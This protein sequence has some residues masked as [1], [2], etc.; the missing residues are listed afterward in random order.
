MNIRY[1]FKT[2]LRKNSSELNTNEKN[3]SFV[4]DVF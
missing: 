2:G 4:G 1:I 3:V